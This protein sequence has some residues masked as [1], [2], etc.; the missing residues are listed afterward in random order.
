MTSLPRLATIVTILGSVS[1]LMAEPKVAFGRWLENQ[2]YPRNLSVTRFAELA[3]LSATAVS[4]WINHGQ[5]PYRRTCYAIARALD[6][7][8]DEVLVAAG[9][10]PEGKRPEPE[11]ER[12]AVQFFDATTLTDEEAAE[13]GRLVAEQL[14]KFRAKRQDK[15]R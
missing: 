6:L 5:V 13:L 14:A 1:V 2:I 12:P 4:N 3:G 8:P 7:D 10:P 9:Y 15:E 11:P